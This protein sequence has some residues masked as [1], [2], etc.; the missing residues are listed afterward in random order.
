MGCQRKHYCCR[1]WALAEGW[2]PD[3]LMCLE[4]IDF[5]S[6]SS[7]TLI[8]A[9]C[10]SSRRGWLKQGLSLCHWIC[11]TKRGADALA[12]PENH[13]DKQVPDIGKSNRDGSRAANKETWQTWPS[14][15]LGKT[16]SSPQIPLFISSLPPSPWKGSIWWT[17][18]SA[19]ILCYSMAVGGV[20]VIGRHQ[21]R[22]R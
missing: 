18:I 16:V 6:H 5:V 3:F 13:Q 8:R 20:G 11:S 14:P 7:S 21:S 10:D 17:F 12:Q 4:N 1:I 15:A 2:V 22:K 9:A 19:V